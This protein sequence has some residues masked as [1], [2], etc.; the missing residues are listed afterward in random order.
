M[1]GYRRGQVR[2]R[3]TGGWGMRG[4]GVGGMD[5][6]H[7]PYTRSGSHA[8]HLTE[9]DALSAG[10]PGQEPGPEAGLT[11]ACSPTARKRGQGKRFGG[12]PQQPSGQRTA[13]GLG[14]HFYK[15]PPHPFMSPSW[16]HRRPQPHTAAGSELPPTSWGSSHGEQSDRAQVRALSTWDGVL[17][18]RALGLEIQDLSHTA[19]GAALCPPPAPHGSFTPQQCRGG[20][21]QEPAGS[22]VQGRQAWG[23]SLS[24]AV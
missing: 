24:P 6:C 4:W 2:G 3:A 15:R 8:L 18:E 23:V 5:K 7:P 13:T 17:D 20:K 11:A 16:K 14:P 12:R 19:R 1:A 10:K 9:R 22:V 21:G